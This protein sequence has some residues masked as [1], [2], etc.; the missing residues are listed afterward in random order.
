ML[1]SPVTFMY[2]DFGDKGYPL[3]NGIFA[4]CEKSGSLIAMMHLKQGQG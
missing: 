4:A 2:S 3:V 1:M